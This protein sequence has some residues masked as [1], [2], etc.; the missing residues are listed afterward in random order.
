MQDQSL[1]RKLNQFIK[2][3]YLNEVVKGL[4]L[5]VAISVV[6]FLLFSGL[7]YLGRFTS[8]TRATLFFIYL[9]GLL[10]ISVYYIIRPLIALFNLRRRL[11]HQ[12]A[13]KII[14]NHFPQV[15]DKLLNALQL[16]EEFKS[17]DSSLLKAT[18]EQRTRALRPLPF[19]NAID[20]ST[21][22][23][24][25]KYGLLPALGLLSILLITPGFKDSSKRV[26]RFQEEFEVPAPFSFLFDASAIKAIEFEPIPLKLKLEG[27]ELP[28][29]VYVHIQGAEFKMRSD[30]IGEYSFELPGLNADQALHF[31]AGGFRS[32]DY[33]IDLLH[34]PSLLSYRAILEFPT[35]LQRENQ[36]LN[37]TGEITIPEG[38]AIHWEF[39]T[40]KVD[41]LRLE[42]ENKKLETS[43]GLYSYSKNFKSSQSFKVHTSNEDLNEGDSL[44]YHIRVIPDLYPKIQFS[45]EEDSNNI[46]SM[47]FL[48]EIAD[49]HGLSKLN[50]FYSHRRDNEVL[51]EAKINIAISGQERQPFFHMWS[52]ADLK[53]QAG[54]E[55][56][57]YFV[58]WDNDGVNG[59]KST[60]STESLF[61]A[62]SLEE[63]EE[64]TEE[65]NQ[66]IKE[67]LSSASSS[68]EDLENEI[69]SV[70]KMLTEK[71]QL[72]W[73]DK[74]KIEDLL[75]KQEKIQEQVKQ[76]IEQ[77]FKKDLQ[78]KAFSPMSERLLEKQE[79]LQE[80]FEEVM[81]DEM[82][83]LM[84][85]IRELMD[86]GKMEQLQKEMENFQLSEKEMNKELDRMLEL[87][88]E[89]ELEKKLEQ[90]IN[91]L[92]D[93]AKDQK[94]LAEKTENSK[95]KDPELQEE[96][97]KLENRTEELKQDL[98]EINEKNQALKSPK[99]LKTPENQRQEAQDK[100]SEAGSKLGKGKN[101]QAADDQ[102]E[103]ADKLQEM[104]EQ[105]Q[106][107]MEQAYE[108]QREE[109]YRA[110]RQILEN[111]IQLSFDQEDVQYGFKENRNYSPKYVDLRQEQARIKDDSRIVEDSLLALSERVIEIQH[112]INEELSRVNNNLDK[113]LAELGERNTNRALVHQQMVMTGYNNL[114]LMLSQSLDQMQKQ[115]AAA[116]ESKGK[117]K[118]NCQKPGEAS[119]K[120]GRRNMNSIKQM[121]KE[122]A[123]QLEEMKN[124]MKKGEKP[125][126]QQ[127][128][129]A[130]AKQAAIRKRMKDL[131]RQLEQSGEAGS[132]GNLEKTQDM[133][134]E[135]EQDLYY[136]RLDQRTMER[137]N[138]IEIKLSEHE[139]AEKEQEQ[140]NKRSSDEG[141]DIPRDI[142]P[143]IEKYLKEKNRLLE[144]INQVSPELRPY[145]EQKVKQFFNQP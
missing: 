107:A 36:N 58:V 76:S 78:E 141:R 24:Y 128:A 125:G 102:K 57:Y 27:D 144:Q 39:R 126:S 16:K 134:D 22:G 54:D 44:V 34:K 130:A 30:K 135:L 64:F 100:M 21:R 20:F 35:Y 137:L 82:K 66:K 47:Y 94:K 41:E 28:Q 31:E 109:D 14:G 103:A 85:K 18:I 110:L 86:Q 104:A 33:P 77:N 108:E 2:K 19:I 23:K 121:Q 56:K 69:E 3:Y 13:A 1:E 93:L 62:P 133:M 12:K 89:L 67:Q 6:L 48:G 60:K 119:Q 52:F 95:K 7:E 29:D 70:E 81:N 61:K 140:D 142:P 91:K 15:K 68:A 55:V 131:Q 129:E 50:F 118:A 46:N 106:E 71:K 117:P 26:L 111:I 101:R 49:D 87:F 123:K 136:K 120:Q 72:D 84:E 53:L 99:N 97:E 9:S 143:E 38:T 74:K 59:S 43:G 5:T 79:K 145:Y 10:G 98:K 80:L 113:G 45:L 83:E 112:F 116:S 42:P 65:M 73:N 8:Q 88:K 92:Q 115:M 96:Q 40:A 90:T 75:K 124:G 127:F 132:L 17:Q 25:L 138:D 122:L 139:K 37:S 32:K 11:D 51:N 114:A 63:L 105:M 4:I